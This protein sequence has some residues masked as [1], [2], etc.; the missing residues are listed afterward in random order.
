MSKCLVAV[1]RY[2][3]LKTDE[4]REALERQMYD[5][6]LSMYKECQ[7]DKDCITEVA[8]CEGRIV[9]MASWRIKRMGNWLDTRLSTPTRNRPRELT[10][11]EKLAKMQASVCAFISCI[12][13]N[14][15]TKARK[16]VE[17]DPEVFARARAMFLK[18]YATAHEFAD[19][20]HLMLV[21]IGVLPEYCRR[22]IATALVQ[23]E[24]ERSDRDGSQITVAA[25][26]STG[27]LFDKL[28]FKLASIYELEKGGEKERI[29]QY[30]AVEDT[31][32]RPTV[33]E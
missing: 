9:G 23:R 16:L 28:N 32:R 3:A 18:R 20:G 30:G 24:C 8:I 12:V 13:P 1:Q 27:K 21:S 19:I 25:W 14:Y 2:A 26:N 29:M 7:L 5:C 4:A 22:G 6:M 10:M 11:L 31:C 17:E 15:F 33:F